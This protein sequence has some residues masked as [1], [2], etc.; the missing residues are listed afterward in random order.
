MVGCDGRQRFQEADSG[1]RGKMF[2]NFNS[3]PDGGRLR[4]QRTG[5]NAVHL[6][7][8]WAKESSVWVHPVQDLAG[9]RARLDPACSPCSHGYMQQCIRKGDFFRQQPRAL[10]FSSS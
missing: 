2:M 8:S 1:S 5:T 7:D 10:V 3:T 6:R 9:A 4:E